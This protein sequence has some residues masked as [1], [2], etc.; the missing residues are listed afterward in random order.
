MNRDDTY[1]QWV[2]WNE[3]ND[4]YL[5]EC[6][7]LITGIHGDNP[8]RLYAELYNVVE[9]VIQHFEAEGCSLPAPRV[10]PVQE[11]A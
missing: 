3:E 8:V 5:G 6:L 11:V 9:G 10:K 1:H 4:A 7:D 2:E